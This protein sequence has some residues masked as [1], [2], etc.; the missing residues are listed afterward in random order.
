MS[1]PFDFL[2]ACRPGA[3]LRTRDRREATITRV[4]PQA[5]VILGEVPMFGPCAWRADGVYR[6]APCGAAGPL[7][8]MA[9]ASAAPAPR[10]RASL[11][12]T[13]APENRPFC[14]D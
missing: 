13:L 2:A 6:D 8:L 5:G 12:E 7:D 10:R 4:V 3:V 11:A 9:P 1:E 14:C